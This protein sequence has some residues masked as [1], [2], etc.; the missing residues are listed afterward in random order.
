M[1]LAALGQ[2]NH[3]TRARLPGI[4]RTRTPPG[5]WPDGGC[6]DGRPASPGWDVRGFYY[7]CGVCSRS[8]RP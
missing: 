5:D 2:I 6:R 1:A 8:N 3:V 4:G 7:A